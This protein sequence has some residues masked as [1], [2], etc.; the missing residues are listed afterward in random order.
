MN[1]AHFEN[2]SDA[3][4]EQVNGGVTVSLSLDNEGVSL[5]GPLGTLSIPNPF[6]LIG[7]AI[8]GT[9]GAAGDL[10]AKFGGALTK[11]GQLFDFG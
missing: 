1:A 8:G 4:L 6:S 3:A 7:K 5:E 11:A 9:L 2:V 10:L